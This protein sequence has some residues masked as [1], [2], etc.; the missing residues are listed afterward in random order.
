MRLCTASRGHLVDEVILFAL[1]NGT[2]RVVMGVVQN[3][4]ILRY[5]DQTGECF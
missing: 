1:A 4:D 3:G 2:G 5:L